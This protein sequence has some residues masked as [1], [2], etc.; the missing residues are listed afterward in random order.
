MVLGMAIL[1]LFPTRITLTSSSIVTIVLDSRAATL[2]C[3]SLPCGTDPLEDLSERGETRRSWA[4][5]P[6]RPQVRRRFVLAS[7]DNRRLDL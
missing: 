4:Q 6:P 7:Y 1:R 2:M 5:I 3:C